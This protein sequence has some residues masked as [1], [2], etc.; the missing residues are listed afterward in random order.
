MEN[1]NMIICDFC[2]KEHPAEDINIVCG[3]N[4][5][6]DCMEDNTSVCTT[7]GEVILNDDSFVYGWDIYCEDCYH[8][9]FTECDD[10]GKIIPRDDCYILANGNVI[11]ESCRYDNY[12]CCS[13]CGELYH[14]YDSYTN[15]HDDLYCY[16]CFEDLEPDAIHNY[17]YKPAPIF[18][19]GNRYKPVLFMGVELEVDRGGE[20][21]CNAQQLLD[22][23]NDCNEHIYIKHDGSLDDGFEIVSHPATLA[24]HSNGME[25]V[26]LMEKAISMGY[27]SHDTDTCGLHVHVSRNG[28]GNTYDEQENN[29]AK[30]VYFVEKHWDELVKFTR[31]SVYRLEDWASRYGIEPTI[32]E[33]YEKAKGDYIRYRAVNL[34]N[35]NTIEFRIFRGTL[36]HSTFIAT[37]QLVNEICDFCKVLSL[38]SIEDTTWDDFV[39]GISESYTELHSYLLERGLK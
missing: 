22:V 15:E 10:C 3:K 16:D 19:G 37:L 38:D 32:K 12:F 25:W 14:I 13:G 39:S 30:V 1:N 18:Y 21:N 20:Y 29:I 34:Q 17:H 26:K 11:C 31:R 28:M 7:C 23:M 6:P 5:C 35:A 27:R 4:I 2:G 24:Y 36:K 8:A 9:Y 33:T